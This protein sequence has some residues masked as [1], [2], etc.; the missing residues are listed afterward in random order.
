M[1]LRGQRIMLDADLARLY[2]V[3]TKALIQAV[4]RNRERFPADFVFTLTNHEVAVLRSQ[5]VTSKPSP[6]GRG[7]RRTAP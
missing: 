1:E 4:K 6:P 5:I 3:S 7:G 2:E